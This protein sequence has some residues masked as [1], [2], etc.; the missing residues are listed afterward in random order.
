MKFQT[1]IDHNLMSCKILN[2]DDY[3]LLRLKAL[4]FESLNDQKL[5]FIK[6]MKFSAVFFVN[7]LEFRN[8]HSKKNSIDS[9]KI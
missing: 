9:T 8:S 4:E 1:R 7:V 3:K 5:E 6:F 2:I